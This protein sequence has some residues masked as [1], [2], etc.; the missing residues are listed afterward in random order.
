M[1]KKLFLFIGLTILALSCGK[2]ETIKVAAA[3]YP[4][5]EIVKI[6]AEDL[7]KEGY[8]TK[9]TLLT[10]Y[11]TA[12]VGLANKDFDANFHQHVPFMEIFNKKN[13]AHLVKV[14]AIYDVYVGFYSKKY[15]SKNEIPNGAKV[16]VPNDPT[17]QDRALRILEKQGL[18]KL[19]QKNGLYN[20]KDVD[21]SIKNLKITALPIPSLVQAYKEAD[22]VFN[23]PSHMLK[24][25]I[26][27]KD[28][29]FLEEGT[30]G[31]YAVVLASREDNKNDKKIQALAKA[32]TSEKVKKF[33]KEKYSKEGYPV[34]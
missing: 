28:A 32:M 5:E 16:V 9:I 4:M 8:D 11:V 7:K 27:P 26:T 17:N 20:L 10:D 15:K 2:K 14:A 34:F 3:G 33:L 30:K 6:A 23:W 1:L 18:I 29:L 12:N 13:N 24:I 21:N 22:L 25:G 31:R 19:K